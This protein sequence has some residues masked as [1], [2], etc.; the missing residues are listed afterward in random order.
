MKGVG[1]SLTYAP[2]VLF[3]LIMNLCSV[4]IATINAFKVDAMNINGDKNEERPYVKVELNN[5]TRNFLYDTGASRTCMKLSTFN[6]N[7]THSH[8]RQ[9]FTSAISPDLLDAS[10]NSLGMCGVFWIPMEI[11]GRKFYHK[12]RVLK[13]VTEDI[14]GIDLIHKQH[15][16]YDPVNRDVFFS[17]NHKNS[18]I[19]LMTEEFMPALTKK[20]IKVKYH[21]T[22]N[23]DQVHVATIYL[24]KS[25]LIQGGPA[26][27]KIDENKLCYIEV[28]N[29]AP[30]DMYLP[31]GSIIGMVEQENK[32]HLQKNGW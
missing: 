12:V 32:D 31:R 21:G 10:G 19:S 16:L 26:L 5:C 2:N 29:C 6:K 27:V 13:H 8:P 28:A 18:V 1:K 22:P 17:A 20:I 14:I 3:S 4:S 9:L 11:M 25:K 30:Y 15:L 7:F 24:D 23:Q